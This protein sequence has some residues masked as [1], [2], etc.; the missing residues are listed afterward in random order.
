MKFSSRLRSLRM[1]AKMS[2][3]ELANAL[4]TKQTTVSNWESNQ[5][6]PSY[7]KLLEIARLFNVSLDYLLGRTDYRDG[8]IIKTPTELVD[9]GVEWV[10]KSG[11]DTLTPVE[12]AAIRKMLEDQ[13]KN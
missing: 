6:E 9:A 8:Y 3:T 4:G 1:E 2:Q 11:S 7:E 5:V 10:E 13:K 12:V